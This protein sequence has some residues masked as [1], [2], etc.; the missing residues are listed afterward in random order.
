MDKTETKKYN[1]VKPDYKTDIN[2]F[3]GVEANPLINIVSAKAIS[4]ATFE[5]LAC[6][7]CGSNFR[8]EIHHIR[9]IKDINPKLDY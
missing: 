9:R 3:L 5:N 8:V 1:F 4:L 2:A 7:L 6:K